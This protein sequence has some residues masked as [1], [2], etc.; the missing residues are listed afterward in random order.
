MVVGISA[1]SLVAGG[2]AVCFYVRR[3]TSSHE[4]TSMLDQNV[5]KNI[6]DGGNSTT[7]HSRQATDMLDMRDLELY[8]IQ[9]MDIQ[10]N[11]V[12]GSGAFA[13][14]WSGT[15]QDELVAINS[16]QSTWT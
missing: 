5:F 16:I 1:A 11:R 15:Y 8:R 10:L 13:D 2:L 12:I 3:R 14:V 9:E 7:H 4:T 6:H